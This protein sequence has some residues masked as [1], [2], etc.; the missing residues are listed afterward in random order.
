[1]SRRDAAESPRSDGSR[2]RPADRPRRD[3]A[4]LRRS[5]YS[6]VEAVAAEVVL[7]SYAVCASAYA[8]GLERPWTSAGN[9]ARNAVVT[10]AYISVPLLVL[11]ELLWYLLA[12]PCVQYRPPERK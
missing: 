3:A 1:M 5:R 10:L 12:C 9:Y 8:S 2:R 6:R 11:G 7:Q 4:T